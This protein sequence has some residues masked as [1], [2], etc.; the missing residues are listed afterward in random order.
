MENKKTIV[1]IGAGVA[2]L[3]TGIYLLRSGYNVILLERNPS[4]GGLCTG[5]Y[6]KGKYI[7]GCI[8][9]LTGTK[10]GD[11]C[12]HIWKDIGAFEDEN[13][14]IYLDTWGD[15]VYE[16]QIVRLLRDYKQAEKEWLELSPEDSKEIKRFFRM[17]KAFIDVKLP[18]DRPMESLTLSSAM[19]VAF[20][21]IKHPSYI[22]TMKMSTEKYAERFK[23]PAIR[24]ALKNAQPGPGNLFSMIFSY[25]TIAADT[26]AV[27]IGGSKPMV[28]RIKNRFLGLGGHLVLNA[29]VKSINTKKGFVTGVTL[30]NGQIIKGEYFISTAGTNYTLDTLLGG[31]YKA[32]AFQKRKDYK[33]YP[34]ITTTMVTYEIEDIGDLSS[35]TTFPI[36]PITIVGKP[37]NFLDIRNFSYDS[38]NFVYGNKTICN[39]MFHEFDE[40]FQK[41]QELY[42]NKEAYRN[43]KN[44]IANEVIN[45]IETQYPQYKGKVNVLDVFTPITLHRYTNATNG[46]YMGLFTNKQTRLSHTGIVNGL[47]NFYLAGQWLEAPGGLPFAA[48]SG[49]WVAMRICKQDGVKFDYQNSV[50]YKKAII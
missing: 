31:K 42:E 10:D 24:F 25:A 8:H 18:M 9:W 5:W 4:V 17:V 29:D 41:W 32:P 47:H 43:E 49:K 28:E 14:L 26:G 21:V 3:S 15:F 7:D 36:E 22:Y 20:S 50:L 19:K 6:R 16:G 35:I 48:A 34:T 33:K 45:R 27:P 1:V 38:K 40:D 37:H 44:R 12:N 2:G 46:A 23:N 11:S 30:K 39:S 13:D